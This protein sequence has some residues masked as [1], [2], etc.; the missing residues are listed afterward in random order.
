ME[1]VIPA[2]LV[3]VAAAF[4]T[5]PRHLVEAEQ[6]DRGTREDR[7]R[8]VIRPEDPGAAAHQRLAQILAGCHQRA[9][10]VA[11]GLHGAMALHTP[12]AVVALGGTTTGIH[13]EVQVGLAAVGMGEVMALHTPDMLEPQILEAV[14]GVAAGGT[15][16]KP[17]PHTTE[18]T[19]A[20]ALSLFVILVPSVVLVAP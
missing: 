20:L 3:G 7:Q 9:E 11:Q 5:V 4:G 17:T 14:A 13:T 12:E 18:E 19:A 6:P 16:R 8:Q 10:P 15:V 2:D 1:V